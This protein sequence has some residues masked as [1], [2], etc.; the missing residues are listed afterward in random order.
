MSSWCESD[1]KAV[2][3]HWH[4]VFFLLIFLFHLLILFSLFLPVSLI[5]S[6]KQIYTCITFATN[7]ELEIHHGLQMVCTLHAFCQPLTHIGDAYL[8]FCK[9]EITD[10]VESVFHTWIQ[11]SQRFI[12]HTLLDY[13]LICIFVA[14]TRAI[15]FTLVFFNNQ[16]HQ[17]DGWRF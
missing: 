6:L 10:A 13:N 8:C 15:F 2:R 16:N 3:W 9:Q 14:L 7:C 4:H 5:K 1:W 12:N 11:N 17:S